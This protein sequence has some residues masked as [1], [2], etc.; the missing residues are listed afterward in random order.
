[1]RE[2]EREIIYGGALFSL[3]N[4]SSF[5]GFYY[6]HTL[7]NS[8]HAC[9]LASNIFKYWFTESYSTN[10]NHTKHMRFNH[11]N[12]THSKHMHAINIGN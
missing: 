7:S 2:R 8:H 10:Y 1:M 11:S 4:L 5:L 12:L 6:S 3:S 9:F